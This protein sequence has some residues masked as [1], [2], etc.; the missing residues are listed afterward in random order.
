[1]SLLKEFKDFAMRGN[2]VDMAVGIIIGAAFGK[3]VNSL[4]SDVI[5]PVVGALLGK[6]NFGD[7]FLWLGSDPRPKTLAEAK[8]SG[9]AYLAF[10]SFLQT[11]L[12]FV[13]IAFAIFMLV[14][15]MNTA[16]ARF[17]GPRP[18]SAPP[19]PEDIQ[20]LREI[21]DSLKKT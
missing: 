14:K 15:A 3:I 20:L 19:V 13:I 18:A 17:E 9:Q 5:M 12:D 6:A 1:M 7:L 16:R 10:G 4:V 11:T 21:R 2:V 8:T